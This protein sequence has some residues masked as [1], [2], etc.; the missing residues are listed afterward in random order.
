M[1][2]VR[3]GVDRIEDGFVGTHDY[4]TARR[5]KREDAIE[6]RVSS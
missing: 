6:S 4:E 1:D 3:K 5:L 2:G